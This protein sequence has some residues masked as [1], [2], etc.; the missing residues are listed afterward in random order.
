MQAPYLSIVVPVYNE[1]ENL[2]TLFTRL[3]TMLDWIGRPYEVLFVNDGSRDDSLELLRRLQRRY[4]R[5]VRVIDLNGN[6]GQH[7]AI[8][9]A[10]ERVRGE[11]VVTL[12]A[13]L[14]NPPEEIPRLVAAIETGH[15]VAG[16][17]RRDRQDYALRRWASHCINFIR[18]RTTH[19]R[20]RD[21]GCMLRAYRRHV[22]DA[23]AASGESS[24][25]IPA[26]ALS[27]AINPTEVEVEHAARL[28]GK[29]KYRL[30]DLIRLNFDLMTGFTV[31]PLQLFTLFGLL[32]AG[33]S[34]AFVVYLSVRRLVVGPEAEGVFTLFAIL[35][36][37]V[38]VG[39]LGLGIIGE[40][41]GRIYQEVRRRPRFVVREVIEDT[42]LPK[43]A[44][45]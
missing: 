24:T 17:Y 25:F 40:Y 5:E 4:P 14:Q 29:S 41:V 33:A 43:A 16:G 26:L 44:L 36:F 23:M 35:Y 22:V 8:M 13:D 2:E 38:G 12:D 37:L 7:M 18:E 3:T 11:V 45:R 1:A 27:Y 31:A 19:I 21:Q 30:Y 15:D 10:F 32:V 39:I 42:E 9:A 20:M 34:L 28:A 6:F